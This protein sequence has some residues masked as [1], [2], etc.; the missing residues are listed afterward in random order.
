M[1]RQSEEKTVWVGELEVLSVRPTAAWGGIQEKV[2]AQWPSSL[3]KLL[4]SR[5]RGRVDIIQAFEEEKSHFSAGTK[6]LTER[7]GGWAPAE[8]Q[9]E[10]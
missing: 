5:G 6:A 7:V 10:E 9:S 4:K 1:A 2:E 3:A 8:P